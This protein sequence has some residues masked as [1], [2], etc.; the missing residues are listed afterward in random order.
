MIFFFH[1]TIPLHY[2]PRRKKNAYDGA[3]ADRAQAFCGAT[4]GL[5]G[6]HVGSSQICI[7]ICRALYSS[8]TEINC[9]AIYCFYSHVIENKR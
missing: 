1:S 3:G 9:K 5:E 6:Q 4:C 2:D 8:R 7:I